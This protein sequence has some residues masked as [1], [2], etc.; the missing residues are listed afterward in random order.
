[1]FNLSSWEK[2]LVCVYSELDIGMDVDDCQTF[3]LPGAS[4]PRRHKYMWS[5]SGQ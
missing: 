5:K 2:P 3:A 4:I 1:M